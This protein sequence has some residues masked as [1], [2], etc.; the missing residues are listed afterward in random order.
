[1]N[2]TYWIPIMDCGS[3]NLQFR[4]TMILV[5]EAY[6]LLINKS[7]MINDTIISDE[8]VTF[9]VLKLIILTPNLKSLSDCP[10]Q[11]DVSPSGEL[12]WTSY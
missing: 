8:L 11:M 4:S 7:R 6:T 12:R 1:M 3:N 5:T 9:R 2:K 10:A